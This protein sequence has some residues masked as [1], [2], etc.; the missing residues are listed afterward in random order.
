[1]CRLKDVVLRRGIPAPRIGREVRVCQTE[2]RLR[3]ILRGAAGFEFQFLIQ[4]IC[5][6]GVEAEFAEIVREVDAR[7][8]TA[9]DLLEP[10][11]PELKR[12]NKPAGV[13]TGITD[14]R[15]YLA[16]VVATA[17][18]VCPHA[19]VRRDAGGHIIEH[20]AGG[21]GT[22]LDLTGALANFD[23]FHP[24]WRGRVI[25]RGS[26]IG[27]RRHQHA[28]LHHRDFAA[29]IGPRSPHPNVRPQTVPVLLL[30][31]EA[32]HLPEHRVDV[33]GGHLDLLHFLPVEQ[34]R[35]PRQPRPRGRIAHD[36][37]AFMDDLDEDNRQGL[38]RAGGHRDPRLRRRQA[39]GAGH[40][41]VDTRGHALKH[42]LTIVVGPDGHPRTIRGTQHHRGPGHQPAVRGLDHAR[43]RR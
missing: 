17:R 26:G 21:D 20:A 41:G 12:F 11:S 6:R 38:A 33:I 3:A 39:D 43:E 31:V 27:R 40:H 2:V 29:A 14:V 16:R 24:A 10:I 4:R 19:E 36:V 30:N 15:G 23:G 1:M 13:A 34:M 22:R 8:S 28:V 35:R 42:E 5:R 37:D 32:G 7:L 18:D 25:G 9:V